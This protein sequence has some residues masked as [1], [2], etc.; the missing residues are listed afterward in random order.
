MPRP[1]AAHLETQ[2]DGLKRSVASLQGKNATRTKEAGLLSGPIEVLRK[3]NF[4]L[5]LHMRHKT[6]RFGKEQRQLESE[7]E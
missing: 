3:E 7:A 4:A 2:A 5:Q 1:V 6:Q